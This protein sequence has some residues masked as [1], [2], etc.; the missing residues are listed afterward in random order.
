[1]PVRWLQI[2]IVSVQHAGACGAGGSACAS[3]GSGRAAGTCL[4]GFEGAEETTGNY[5]PAF[6]FC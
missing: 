5:S 3:L 4:T 6:S 1:M 2:G